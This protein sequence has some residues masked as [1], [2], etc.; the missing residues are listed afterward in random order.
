MT[1]GDLVTRENC[2]ASTLNAD[3]TTLGANNWMPG[4]TGVTA[5]HPVPHPEVFALWKHLQ[6]TAPAVSQGILHNSGEGPSSK[7]SALP[8]PEGQPGQ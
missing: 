4:Q 8:L 1:G 5:R 6:M 3:C 7:P 2:M